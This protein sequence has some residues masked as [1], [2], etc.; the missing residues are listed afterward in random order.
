MPILKRVTYNTTQS[1]P[2]SRLARIRRVQRKDQWCFRKVIISPLVILLIPGR[3]SLR[4]HSFP[5]PD[6]IGL[7]WK[8]RFYAI[9]DNWRRLKCMEW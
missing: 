7:Q 8:N 5:T 6:S 3:G 4:R 1:Q 2:Q 9:W